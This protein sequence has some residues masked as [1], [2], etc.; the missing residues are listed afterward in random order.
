MTHT[1]SGTF[2][3]TLTP[4]DIDGELMGR[5]LIDKRFHGALD[6]V[7]SG[8]MLS[9]GTATK[10]SAV[11]VAIE[12]VRGHLDGRAGSFVLHHTGVMDHGA[13]SL[14]IAVAPDSGTEALEGL[15]GSMTIVVEGGR[16]Q[17]VM[18][19]DLPARD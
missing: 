9:A 18:T 13:P 16:H 12:R 19:Y 8:Q 5:Q 17:Y 4:L 7:S 6:A 3:V 15:A 14:S 10:G 11:Y 1:A 2:D